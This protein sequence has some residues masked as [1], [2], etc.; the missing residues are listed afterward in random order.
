MKKTMCM[1]LALLMIL[2][3]TA[4]GQKKQEEPAEEGFR[5]VLPDIVFDFV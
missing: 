5:T 1:L 2:A 4:C 3:L